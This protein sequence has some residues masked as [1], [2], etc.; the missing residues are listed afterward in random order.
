M[1]LN[2]LTV[3]HQIKQCFDQ[4]Y[5]KWETT[6]EWDRK[7]H[8]ENEFRHLQDW[9]LLACTDLE[10]AITGQYIGNLREPDKYFEQF[11]PK[12]IISPA[13][14]SHSQDRT[15]ACQVAFHKSDY[16]HPPVSYYRATPPGDNKDS[17][18]EP[19]NSLKYQQCHVFFIASQS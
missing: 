18:I 7:I 11:H 8:L 10:R 14:G 6:T 16:H 9:W 12:R 19:L 5:K 15:C 1:L 13:V 4:L 17:L 2:M 3:C